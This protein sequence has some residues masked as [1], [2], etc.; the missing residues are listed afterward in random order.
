MKNFIN[1]EV[2]K[3]RSI[4]K[5]R[6]FSISLMVRIDGRVK[7]NSCVSIKYAPTAWVAVLEPSTKQHNYMIGMIGKDR[8]KFLPRFSDLEFN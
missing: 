4:D 8:I 5:W 2:G 3:F 1:V 6:K 7:G